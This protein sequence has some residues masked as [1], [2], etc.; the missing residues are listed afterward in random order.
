MTELPRYSQ[1]PIRGDLPPRSAWGLWGDDDEIGAFNLLTPE[2]V[3]NALKSIRRGS[4]FSLN[5]AL[6]EPN[7][8]L[9]GRGALRHRM[10]RPIPNVMDDVLDNFFPQ[11]SSQ[12]DGL[13]HV[14]HPEYGFYNGR[15][16]D[17]F[18]GQA[19][20]KNGVEHWARRGIV[21][22]GVLLDIALHWQVTGRQYDAGS[23]F[24]F[25]VDDLE[26]VREAQGLNFEL[27]DILLLRTGWMN[28]YSQASNE[29]RLDLSENSLTR[30][31]VPGLAG[32][33][34]MVEWLWDHHFS[35]VAADNPSVEAWPHEIEVD[36]YLH[37]RLLPLLGMSMGEMWY[38]EELA[39]DCAEDGVY[40]F[41]LT[42]AP[43]NKLG[44][45]GSPANAIAIK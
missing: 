24:E 11:G 22:R 16:A 39:A 29:V 5:W 14:G 4:V 3:R 44:G 45:V 41:L 30:L 19:G 40:E 27:G 10:S 1:L 2:R 13:S 38:L 37:F 26:E 36:S 18:T 32:D 9:Y 34:T 25:S 17:D 42:S 23:R 35:A 12:W 15:V 31:R 28:W 21:G 33:E 8:P 20:T 43:L 7:P 6:E